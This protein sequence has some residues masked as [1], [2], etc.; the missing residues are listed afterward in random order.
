MATTNV[1]VLVALHLPLILCPYWTL[2][3][4]LGNAEQTWKKY[5]LRSWYLSKL[6]NNTPNIFLQSMIHMHKI[7]FRVVLCI[8]WWDD[9]HFCFDFILWT[10][11]KE[12]LAEGLGAALVIGERVPQLPP[13]LQMI[14]DAP[15]LNNSFKFGHIDCIFEKLSYSWPTTSGDM[16]CTQWGSVPQRKFLYKSQWFPSQWYWC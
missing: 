7:G 11:L 9:L 2:T 5:P 8:K 15:P 6:W 1:S 3:K 13:S 12:N 10:T 16:K 14:A 4:H